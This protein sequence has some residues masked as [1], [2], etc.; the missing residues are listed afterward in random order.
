MSERSQQCSGL[1]GDGY[2]R[3]DTTRSLHRTADCTYCLNPATHLTNFDRMDKLIATDDCCCVPT[4]G[5]L[6]FGNANKLPLNKYYFPDNSL[7][8]LG[9]GRLILV[10]KNNCAKN[11]QIF[12]LKLLNVLSRA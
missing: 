1:K 4:S 2:R 3:V 9:L 8:R 5:A 12:F 10:L 7:F 6:V 11:N